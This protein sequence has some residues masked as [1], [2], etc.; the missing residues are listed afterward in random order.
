M[1]T[2]PDVLPITPF[3][4]PARGEVVIPGSKSLTNRAL[5]LAA[6]CDAPVLLTGALFSEDT[7]LM[8]EALR[9]L[10]LIVTGDAAAGTVRV[11]RQQDA[12]KLGAADLFVG[13]AGTAARFL[14]ALCAAAP[15]GIYRLDGVPQMRKRP[16]QGLIA[17]LRQLDADIRC[18]GEEGFFPLEIR[19]AGL[20]GGRVS[21]DARE[22]SQLLSAL[23]MVAPLALTPVEI[24]LVGDVRWPFV[25]MT[26]RLME[27]F[28]QPPVERRGTGAFTVAN[29]RRYALAGGRYAIEP[30][31]TAAS[32]FLALPLAVGGRLALPGLRGPC[33]GLQG[34]IQFAAVL[35]AVGAEIAETSRSLEASC[36]RGDPRRGVERDFNEFSDTFLTL[37]ALAPLLDGPTR[38][39]GLAHT[40]KQET[41]RVAGM[42]CELRKLGQEV[43]EEEDA[44]TITPRPL[45]AGQ[46]IETYG[47]HR[48]AMSFGI[49]GCHDRHGD[50]RPWLSIRNPACCAKTFPHFFELLETVRQNSV[51]R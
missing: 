42:A 32:Y 1:P 38:I 15:Y 20:R 27:H 6:L 50:G 9:R 18:T 25:Q 3:T 47:D 28:G 22:S 21:I 5:L 16:M 7:E 17:A 14:T 37:A 4:R 34:D 31:A 13:L 23:L 30:D 40:R 33:V 45:R 10:G 24:A 39:T 41:D 11:S 35:R 48:F 29:T 36:A 44:L 49:L 19:A 26:A 2:L 51:G 43:V 46:E 8:A 12:F